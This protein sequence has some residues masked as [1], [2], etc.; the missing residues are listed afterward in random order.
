MITE[1]H[2]KEGLS[3]SY[4]HA[5]A[6]LAGVNLSA[7]REFDYGID[8]TL[9]KVIFRNKRRVENGI[10]LDFQLKCT[11]NWK[12]E[13]DF[14]VYDLESKTYND[15]VSREPFANGLILI[16]MC[17]PSDDPSTWLEVSENYLKIQKCCYFFRP[18]GKTVENEKSTKRIRIPRENI[19]TTEA[20]QLALEEERTR[21][22]RGS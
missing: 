8:G 11:K 7:E 22:I 13:G 6:G 2:I 4:I 17:L 16:L 14:V 5:L 21:R 18:A 12:F 1:Q 3:R 9:R 19:L 20:I 10:P 15:I